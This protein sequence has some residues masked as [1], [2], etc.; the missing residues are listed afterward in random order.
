MIP[1]GKM[2]IDDADAYVD[3]AAALL[4]LPIAPEWKPRVV[5]FVRLAQSMARL[6]EETGALADTDSAAVFTLRDIP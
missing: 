6:V 2:A 4:D 1:G 5:T 3:A